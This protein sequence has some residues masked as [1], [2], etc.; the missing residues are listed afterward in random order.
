VSG[1]VG[2]HQQLPFAAGIQNNNGNNKTNICRLSDFTHKHTYSYTHTHDDKFDK[3]IMINEPTTNELKKSK[4][5]L[6]P[7]AF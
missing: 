6:I 5:K 2:C 3:Q 4:E 7:K 1:V